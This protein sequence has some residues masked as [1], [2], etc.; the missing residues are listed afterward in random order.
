MNR[1]LICIIIILSLGCSTK[2][3]EALTQTLIA[4]AVGAVVGG[5]SAPRGERPEA[6]AALWGASAGLVVGGVSLYQMSQR[7]TKEESDKV[8]ALSQELA[9]YKDQF[10]PKLQKEGVGLN[11]SPLP[12]GLRGFVRPGKWKHYKLDRWVKDEAQEN[13]WVRQTE[14]FEFIPPTIN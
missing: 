2:P 4:S 9:Q 6:H 10:E 3:K 5:L 11:E 8:R 7:Q 1:A 14:I 12:Q 13:I